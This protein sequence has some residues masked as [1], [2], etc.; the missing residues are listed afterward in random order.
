[1]IGEAFWYSERVHDPENKG[2]QKQLTV[3]KSI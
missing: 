1:M 3:T 2:N